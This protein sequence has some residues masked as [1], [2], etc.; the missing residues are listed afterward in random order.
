MTEN[1]GY[2]NDNKRASLGMQGGGGGGI[3]TTN[4]AS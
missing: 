1:S 2:K 3:M 4:P